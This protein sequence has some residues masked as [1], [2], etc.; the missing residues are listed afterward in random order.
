M[1]DVL[2][3]AYTA[4]TLFC[5]ISVSFGL[6]LTMK[7][8]REYLDDIRV[9]HMYVGTLAKKMTDIYQEVEIDDDT[10]KKLIDEFLKVQRNNKV[11]EYAEEMKQFREE[12]E[13]AMTKEEKELMQEV[14]EAD[15]EKS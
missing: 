7:D 14:N 15:R 11:K 1:Y 12:Q 3:I 6:V 2:A 9:Q 4:V 8:T 13:Q 5:L 10:R